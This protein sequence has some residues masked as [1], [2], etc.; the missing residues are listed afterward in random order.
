MIAV[1][2]TFRRREIVAMGELPLNCEMLPKLIWLAFV[3]SGVLLIIRTKR[4]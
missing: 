2:S 1:E 4:K 3:G